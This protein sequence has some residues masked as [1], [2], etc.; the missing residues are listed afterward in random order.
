MWLWSCDLLLVSHV[1]S[2]YV[3]ERECVCVCPCAMYPVWAGYKEIKQPLPPRNIYV[4]FV[5][6]T[7]SHTH[8]RE[9]ER[10]KALWSTVHQAGS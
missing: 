8:M 9:R 3:G 4:Y 5:T 10:E 2:T 7:H 6:Y 1:K